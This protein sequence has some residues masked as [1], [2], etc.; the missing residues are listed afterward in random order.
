MYHDLHRPHRERWLPR[1]RVTT[2]TNSP[3]HVKQVDTQDNVY[4]DGC[5]WQFLVEATL[6]A[7]RI[8]GEDPCMKVKM[9]V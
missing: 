4:D 2:G 6:T 1:E 8:I 7:I 9:L 5:G 3:S